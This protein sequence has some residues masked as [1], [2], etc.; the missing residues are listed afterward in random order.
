MM[1]HPELIQ[2]EKYYVSDISKEEAMYSKRTRVFAVI[3]KDKKY[4]EYDTG[5]KKLR[6]WKFITEIWIVID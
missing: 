3:Y 6:T 1:K 5:I 2:G 4:F